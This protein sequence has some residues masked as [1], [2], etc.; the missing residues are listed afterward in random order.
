MASLCQ[1]CQKIPVV[2]SSLR[3][4]GDTNRIFWW[5]PTNDDVSK[6][7]SFC[8]LMSF[9]L[10]EIR[11]TSQ[12]QEPHGD[13]FHDFPG[14]SGSDQEVQ[15]TWWDRAGPTGHGAFLIGDPESMTDTVLCFARDS[16]NLGLDPAFCLSNRHESRVD[17][18]Q[19]RAW[20][21]TC[22]NGHYRLCN[23]A[24][25]LSA[26]NATVLRTDYTLLRLIDA[27]ANCLIEVNPLDAP[28]YIALSY[29][30]GGVT[31]FRL[32][33]ANK[34]ELMRAGCLK[35]IWWR[36]P[37]TIQDSISL[38][39]ELKV[40]FLWVDSLCILQNDDHDMYNGIDSMDLI[41]QGAH[42]TIVAA[43]GHDANSGLPGV[44]D[45][46]RGT[47]KHAEEIVPGVHLDVF[48][49]LDPLLKISSYSKRAWT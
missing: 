34:A 49:T 31:N 24:P 22:T 27:T 37:R 18:G 42:L 40:P 44:Q 6:T 12:Q 33:T 16:E 20:L 28:K 41:Y 36:L 10:F 26:A 15:L 13:H 29:V 2:I 48:T 17:V 43:S 30:W 19:V 3:R 23:K 35:R 32:T 46:S 9:A 1:G 11:R 7:C 4:L 47:S 21:S 14:R 5:H 8:S 38:A 25:D 45:N 39:R